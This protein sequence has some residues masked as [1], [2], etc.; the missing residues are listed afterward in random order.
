MKRDPQ[1]NGQVVLFWVSVMQS[2]TNKPF[3]LSVVMLNFVMLGVVMLSVIMLNFV[4][5]CAVMLNV[6]IIAV[7]M[8][9]VMAPLA[10]ITSVKDHTHTYTREN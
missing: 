4:M 3:M 5:L 2:V 8:L 6:V 1:H 10:E 9:N 7:I